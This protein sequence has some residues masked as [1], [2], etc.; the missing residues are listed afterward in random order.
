M[1]ACLFPGQGSQK[2]GMGEQLFSQFPDYVKQ[3]DQIL[4]Y[5]I[6]DLCLDDPGGRLAQTHYTQP[7]I[8]V[9]S[10]LQYLVDFE[11]SNKPDF[12]LGHSVGEYA[13]LFAAESL[14]FS[15]G[16]RLVKKRG[17]LMSQAKGGGMAAVVGVSLPE[18]IEL[19]E[20]SPFMGIEI[21]NINAPDQI[22]IGGG[23]ASMGAFSKYLNQIDFTGR[24]IPLNVSGA[25]HTRLMR[26][27]QLGFLKFLQSIEFSQTTIPVIS[28]LTARVN[29]KEEI[30]ENLVRHLASPVRWV[31]C[32]EHV[33]GSGAEEFHE[34]GTRVLSPMVSKIRRNYSDNGPSQAYEIPKTPLI[35]SVRSVNN[36]KTPRLPRLIASGKHHFVAN[37]DLVSALG[38]QGVVSFLNTSTL[39]ENDLKDTISKLDEQGLEGQYGVYINND[40]NDV[41]LNGI[42][43]IARDAKVKY[44]ELQDTIVFN[45]A[46]VEHKSVMAGADKAA[47]GAQ[48]DVVL[49]LR[50]NDIDLI[51]DAL[52]MKDS[53]GVSFIDAIILENDKSASQTPLS[54][55]EIIHQIKAFCLEHA[56]KC[57]NGPIQI[58]ISDQL[59][60]NDKAQSDF[61]ILDALLACSKEAQLP[62]AYKSAIRQ[63]FIRKDIASDFP[64]GVAIKRC[65]DWRNPLLNQSTMA[66][67]LN[68][69]WLEESEVFAEMFHQDRI[70][71]N[72]LV[73]LESP[74]EILP[75][76]FL[77]TCRGMAKPLFRA[78]VYKHIKHNVSKAIIPLT[79]GVDGD[80]SLPKEFSSW[81]AASIAKSVEQQL[82]L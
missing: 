22:V 2:K 66:L 38:N 50:A 53:R 70:T 37:E 51:Q 24:F 16:L 31:E 3:A 34:V 6:V 7:A 14:D 80:S 5:S 19:I 67:V 8:Y 74:S 57:Q 64:S 69:R 13:A 10:C 11:S 49:Y 55:S 71:Y 28:N 79:L 81:D 4:G 73:Q 78:A 77:H 72:E 43:D 1:K 18:F 58:G 75:E 63:T 39:K 46:L 44:L 32:I 35:E 60:T 29:L 25:F 41:H 23:K 65:L 76:T 17:E 36:T 9:V 26:F 59:P 40:I 68:K 21:A 56:I 12:L 61:M 27:A 82:N 52:L 48:S 54:V 47:D 33:I 30:P 45:Q 20:S 62:E 15:D 42:L